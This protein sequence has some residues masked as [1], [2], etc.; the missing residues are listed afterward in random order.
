[1]LCEL[2]SP[3]GNGSLFMFFFNVCG[4][5]TVQMLEEDQVL[6]G[7]SA[8]GS[9]RQPC[10][11]HRNG[12]PAQTLAARDF[13][14]PEIP[15]TGCLPV[16]FLKTW[17]QAQVPQRHPALSLAPARSNAVLSLDL[18]CLSQLVLGSTSNCNWSD[19]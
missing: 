7:L 4:G 17:E 10:G 8:L 14:L 15:L 19:L 13:C 18:R 2:L 6:G 1:M 3:D 11:H 9:S 5:E 16:V 12:T